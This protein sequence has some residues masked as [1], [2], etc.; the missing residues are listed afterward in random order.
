MKNALQDTI[1]VLLSLTVARYELKSWFSWKISAVVISWHKV[2]NNIPKLLCFT[3]LLLLW[4]FNRLCFHFAKLISTQS[5]FWLSRLMH[6]YRLTIFPAMMLWTAVLWDLLTFDFALATSFITALLSSNCL[7]TLL[8]CLSVSPISFIWTAVW[9]FGVC[10]ED[11]LDLQGVDVE[12]TLFLFLSRRFNEVLY[13]L[14]RL[15][16]SSCFFLSCLVFIAR[17][18]C[19]LFRGPFFLFGNAILTKRGPCD[20]WLSY[21]LVSMSLD[22]LFCSAWMTFFLSRCR[23]RFHCILCFGVSDLV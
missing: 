15:L 12:G 4:D 6:R 14:C 5:R 3:F 16:S 21:P 1:A 9:R 20:C 11:V 22:L 18:R 2:Y 13:F 23:L 10:G 17:A 19:I 7:R 8:F